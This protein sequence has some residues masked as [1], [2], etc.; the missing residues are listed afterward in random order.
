MDLCH[1]LSAREK[2]KV[3]NAWLWFIF[4]ESRFL[5]KVTD[6]TLIGDKRKKTATS[7]NIFNFM[8]EPY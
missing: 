3:V 7:L 8:L 2:I 1:T 5:H 6:I 4:T